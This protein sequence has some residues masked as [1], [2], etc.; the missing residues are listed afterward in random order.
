MRPFPF[1]SGGCSSELQ[2]PYNFTYSDSREWDMGLFLSG[3]ISQPTLSN[4]NKDSKY[5]HD[6]MLFTTLFCYP[7][8]NSQNMLSLHNMAMNMNDIYV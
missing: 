5:Y 1:N 7:D 4:K 3:T 2:C 6:S 8:L